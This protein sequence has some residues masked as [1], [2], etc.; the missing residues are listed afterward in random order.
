[1]GVREPSQFG[2]VGMEDTEAAN[3]SVINR[4]VRRDYLENATKLFDAKRSGI[5]ILFSCS[6][7][8][9]LRVVG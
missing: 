1:M 3:W 5:V 4:P 7:D 2:S 8:K 9:S 6:N